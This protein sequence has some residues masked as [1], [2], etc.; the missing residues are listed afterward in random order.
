MNNKFEFAIIAKIKGIN[1]KFLLWQYSRHY[2]PNAKLTK[3]GKKKF[4]SIE[5]MYRF[6]HSKTAIQWI[7]GLKRDLKLG[8][9]KKDVFEH[10]IIK[11]GM[12]NPHHRL[13]DENYPNVWF[14]I[15][16]VEEIYFE[17]HVYEYDKVSPHPNI[18]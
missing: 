15:K 17:M 7:L 18:E 4:N 6:E 14:P 12:F 2:N 9:D 1:K 5:E 16:D 3:E 8:E 10:D 11:N 13:N